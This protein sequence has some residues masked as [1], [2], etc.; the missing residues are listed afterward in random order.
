MNPAVTLT[1]LR[2]R[3]I[4]PVDAA[5]YVYA[6]GYT[7]DG[8]IFNTN[9]DYLVVK[10]GPDG[11]QRWAQRYDGPGVNT[12]F[13]EQVVVDAA[14]NVYATGFSYGFPGLGGA[15]LMI[16]VLLGAAVSAFVGPIG[17][18]GGFALGILGLS[19]IATLTGG[20]LVKGL[21]AGTLGAHSAIVLMV[22][23]D[24][25]SATTLIELDS[26]NVVFLV[27][28]DGWKYLSSGVYTKPIDELEDIDSTVWW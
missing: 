13:A 2:L 11:M 17:A 1:F 7:G 26:G 12:D 21:I 4:A 16:S 8:V 22:P 28:D 9:Y 10:F 24:G 19:V 27:P 5:G 6:A 15:N 25:G 3:K 23:A 18:V 20:S 14:G